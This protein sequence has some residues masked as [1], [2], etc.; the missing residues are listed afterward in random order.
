MVK[1]ACIQ[2]N[3]AL[4]KDNNRTQLN[5]NQLQLRAKQKQIPI[6]EICSVTSTINPRQLLWII[7]SAI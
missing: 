6:Q 7:F 4:Y 2:L 5:I 1:K 3:H